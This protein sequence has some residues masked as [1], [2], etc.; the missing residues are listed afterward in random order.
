[1]G[2]SKSEL[3]GT[4]SLRA[5]E[6]EFQDSGKRER[7]AGDAPK[8]YLIFTSEGRVSAIL[9]GTERAFG[10][11]DEELASLF[12]SLIAYSGTY[13]VRGDHFVTRVDVSWNEIWNGTEQVRNFSIQ[14]DRLEIVSA[15]L[16]YP[17]LP[18][19][20]IVRVLLSWQRDR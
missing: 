1:V 6:M 20:P 13:N 12:K 4:W 17:T 5:W 18:G 2:G 19:S 8:G 14:D 3:V 10:P 15:W 9:T 11:S 16:P 7:P